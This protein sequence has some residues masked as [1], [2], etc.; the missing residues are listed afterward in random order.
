[1]SDMGLDISKFCRCKEN[2]K[3]FICDQATIKETTDGKKEKAGLA[4][5]KTETLMPISI[6]TSV[7]Q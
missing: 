6:G 5:Q 3:S 1:M 2:P 7:R 4:A